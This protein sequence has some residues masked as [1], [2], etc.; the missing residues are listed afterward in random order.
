MIFS[1]SMLPV[2]SSIL[3][4]KVRVLFVCLIESIVIWCAEAASRA[5]H[6]GRKMEHG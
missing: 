6:S 5:K 2:P 3:V 4:L 1:Y